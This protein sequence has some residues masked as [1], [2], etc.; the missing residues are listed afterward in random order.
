MRILVIHG[1]SLDQ[2]GVRAPQTYGRMTLEDVNNLI[3]S[4]AHSL[5]VD[6]DIRQSNYEG[7]IVEWIWGARGVFDWIVIN[8]A[9]YTHYSIAIRDALADCGI[10]GIEVHISNIA[11]REEFRHRSVVSPVVRGTISG[12][13]ARGYALALRA[14]AV[15]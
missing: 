5:G 11:A 9:A 14:I 13:G 12:L 15:E 1:P 4:E 2:L 7:Q 3:K 10:P 6:V 8:P